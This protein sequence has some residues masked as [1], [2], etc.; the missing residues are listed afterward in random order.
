MSVALEK[1][2][3]ILNL[4]LHFFS[5]LAKK[6]S[7][8]AEK[9]RARGAMEPSSRTTLS[10][11]IRVSPNTLVG[12]RPF[13]LTITDDLTKE[14]ENRYSA[15]PIHA[16]NVR[17]VY[18]KKMM[19]K[20]SEMIFADAK[21]REFKMY[22]APINLE[23]ELESKRNE[24]GAPVGL[25]YAIR[26]SVR[27]GNVSEFSSAVSA[28]RNVD[29]KP[30][31]PLLLPSPKTRAS[32]PPTVPIAP[33]PP[34]PVAYF[35]P[36]SA[37]SVQIPR[38]PQPAPEIPIDVPTPPPS[39]PA[40]E[41]SFPNDIPEATPLTEA[42]EEALKFYDERKHDSSKDDED[43][44]VDPL[45][46]RKG[47]E[48][49][50]FMFRVAASASPTIANRAG[51]VLQNKKLADEKLDG[52]NV[53]NLAVEQPKIKPILDDMWEMIANRVTSDADSNFTKFHFADSI[54]FTSSYGSLNKNVVEAQEF[55]EFN[56]HDMVT[57]YFVD[58]GF[59]VV[60]HWRWVRR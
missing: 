29:F 1:K 12:H 23:V 58:F 60:I 39:P 30:V 45:T 59:T 38:P 18:S 43:E 6:K 20:V 10:G 7:K 44:E 48:V 25:R 4:E 9:K 21:Q 57:I 32:S 19:D 51:W 17:F 8:R 49:A 16:Y 50:E 47:S 13:D 55:V 24:T 15:M 40:F 36:A 3:Q 33:P 53:K 35:P 56:Q 54:K 42:E 52:V 46:K 28:L 5:E 22:D 37:F 2:K 41:F 11:F 26:S 31:P 14:I 34:A 27:I